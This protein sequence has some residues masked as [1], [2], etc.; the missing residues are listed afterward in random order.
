MIIEYLKKLKDYPAAYPNDIEYK[1]EISGLTVLEIQ[2]LE[3][4]WNGGK[5]FPKSLRELLYLAGKKCYCV[6][7][8]IWS[9]QQEMQVGLR[10]MM[11]DD[12]H[13]F[14][15]PFYI[16]DNYGGDQFCFVYLDEDQNDPKVYEYVGDAL[17]RND[18]LDRNLG[19]TLSRMIEMGVE[20]VK[21]GRN[22]F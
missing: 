22:P 7:Y 3:Q 14:S 13:N 10:E 15:R 6:D 9:S 8:N 4:A 20:A 1:D 12:G 18:V 17:D 19:Y 2:Q 16:V 5:E 21:D 11:Q